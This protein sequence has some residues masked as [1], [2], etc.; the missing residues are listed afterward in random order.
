MNGTDQQEYIGI[1]TFPSLC[2]HLIV[3]QSPLEY[4]FLFVVFHANINIPPTNV[5]TDRTTFLGCFLQ[6]IWNQCLPSTIF[7]LR[8]IY[9]TWMDSSSSSVAYST[10]SEIWNAKQKKSKFSLDWAAIWT[11]EKHTWIVLFESLRTTQ[12]PNLTFILY[13]CGTLQSP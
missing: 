11:V 6:S 12:P 1:V 3:H 5:S 4:L 13:F 10:N 9:H 2:V 8:S 7:V